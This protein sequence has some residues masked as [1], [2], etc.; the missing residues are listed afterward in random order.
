M[1]EKPLKRG[2]AWIE[3]DTDALAHN[4]ADIRS[5]SPKNNE[6]M[7]VVKANAYGHG[8]GAI[9]E[10]LVE[11]G[12]KVFA[13]ST[14]A[15]GVQLRQH[16]PDGDILVMGYTHPL[17]A[18]LLNKNNLI[19]LVADG[20]HANALHGSGQRIRVHIAIDTGMHRLGIE[21][22]DFSGIESIF[23]LKNLNIEGVATH[24]A[25]PDCLTEKEKIFSNTQ[26]EKFFSLV[27]KLKEKG[28]N[29]GKL[30]AHSS[31]GI[32]NYPEPG[33]DYTRP[34]IMMYGVQSQ[35]D[36]T[37][38][39]P[40]LRPVLSL[41]A[42]IAQVRWIKAG[43]SVSYG[44]SYT[45]D[46]DIKLATVSIGYA[47]GIPRQ[48]SGKNGKAIVHGKKVPVIG[49]I[50]MD[51]LMLD[52]TDA[53]DVEAGDVATFIG[54]DNDEEIRCEDVAEAARTITNDILSGLSGRLPR[55]VKEK[56]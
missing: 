3:I 53:E 49:R 38:L 26:M 41:R 35:N 12:I 30:H 21:P 44:R 11:E 4:I 32:Y 34:G 20:V 18:G 15:E 24:L 31:Y 19:Q 33:C 7:A 17:D 55:I 8:V 52:V 54:R 1:G 16:V 39:K 2:R 40:D 45:A 48:M 50:C 36:E 43:E 13:V 42:V 51:M 23:G 29:T 9:A 14:I 5:K 10:R 56:E 27:N 25:S 37:L 22:S 47:D 6:I 46:R 28:Y